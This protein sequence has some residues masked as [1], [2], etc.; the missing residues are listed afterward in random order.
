MISFGYGLV[1]LVGLFVLIL[2]LIFV[3]CGNNKAGVQIECGHSLALLQSWPFFN[4][5][6]SVENVF[7]DA[8]P[9]CI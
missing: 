8:E 4:I 1:F 3:L 9:S 2:F 6:L 7:A 5:L